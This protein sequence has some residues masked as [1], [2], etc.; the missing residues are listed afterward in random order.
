MIGLYESEWPYWGRRTYTVR[1]TSHTYNPET[2]DLVP[3]Q[4][5]IDEEVK[6]I[7]NIISEERDVFNARQEELAK[8]KIRLLA[9]KNKS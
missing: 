6:R 5:Y 2:H 4:S 9:L 8:E 7:D 1:A 3:K